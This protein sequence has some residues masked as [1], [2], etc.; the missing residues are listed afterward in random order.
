MV[1]SM[2]GFGQAE[3]AIDGPIRYKVEIRSVNHRYLDI[4]IRM[5]RNIQFLEE[6]VRRTVQGS[7]SRGRVEVFIT[8]QESESENVSVVVNRTLTAA[9]IKALHEIKG[10]CSLQEQPDLGMICRLPD[11]MRVEKQETDLEQIWHH[12]APVVSKA[13]ESL[14]EQRRSEGKNL[15]ADIEKHLAAVA[16]L[17][18]E[19]EKRAPIVVD[20]YRR[21]LEDRLQTYLSDFEIDQARI[22]TEAAVF[23]DRSSIN[24]ELVRLRS[25]LSAYGQALCEKVPVGRKLDFIT[26]ELLREINTIGSKANDYDLT[27]LV[28]DMKTELEKIREQVQNIE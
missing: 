11:V 13:L 9:Y 22:L 17:A 14:V 2:T 16:G 23:A 25:H 3:N 15:A 24:E 6:K 21:K 19:V 8:T 18:A 10:L 12:L 26:Q 20:E 27:R 7:L 28:V 1:S 4:S 5:P